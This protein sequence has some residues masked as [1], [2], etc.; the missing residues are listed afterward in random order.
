MNPEEDGRQAE[1][2]L[3]AHGRLP[4]AASATGPINYVPRPNSRTIDEELKRD[5]LARHFMYTSAQQAAYDEVNWGISLSALWSLSSLFSF[6]TVHSDSKLPSK[7]PLPTSTF[8]ADGSD[9]VLKSQHAPSLLDARSRTILDHDRT[10]TRQ[11][12]FYRKP[13]ENIAPLPRAQQISGYSGCIGGENIREIDNPTV[14]F[15]PFTVVRTEQPKFGVNLLYE[16][17]ILFC[18]VH[19][20]G[21]LHFSKPNIPFY[22]GRTH[23]TK[24]DPVSHYDRDGRPYTTTAAFHK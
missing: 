21:R 3:R 11:I 7:L 14:E 23:W 13:V 6:F 12:N 19:S 9:P 1:H 16:F 17:F 4:S 22:T 15:K 2:Y 10:Q 18:F 24:T 20:N 5:E 8:E